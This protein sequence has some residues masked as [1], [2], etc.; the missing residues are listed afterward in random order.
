MRTCSAERDDR[1]D[2]RGGPASDDLALYKDVRLGL[3]MC[4]ANTLSLT[5]LHLALRRGDRR[6]VLEAIDRLHDLDTRIGRLVQRL[7][8]SANDDP[9][10]QAIS[11]YVDEQSMAV[12]FEKLALVSQ[13]SGPDMRSASPHGDKADWPEL[14]S[15]DPE[16]SSDDEADQVDPAGARPHLSP[17]ALG[18]VL[19]VA[20]FAALAG[21]VFFA[22]GA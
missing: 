3:Q 22:L 19:T 1:E 17:K 7:P 11:R 14:S 2:S 9:E 12:A 8:V 6:C 15:D 20:M 18:L 10:T 5:R 16:L 4:R 21:A 13:V